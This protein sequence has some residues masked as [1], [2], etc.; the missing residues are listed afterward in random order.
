MFNRLITTMD[1][2]EED[3]YNGSLIDVS[4]K[5]GSLKEYQTVVAVGDTVRGIKVGDL[6]CVN[7]SRYAVMKHQPGS[8]KDGIIED[9]KVKYYNFN[10]IDI[11]GKVHLML[12][13]QDIDF[14]ILESRDE[15]IGPALV[16]PVT[17]KII[18]EV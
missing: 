10:T 17:P 6:V 16:K 2:Y 18:T 5:A 4:K 3:Q 7:P 8:M 14:V 1:T 12:Y 9:N 11:D 13:D 15:E